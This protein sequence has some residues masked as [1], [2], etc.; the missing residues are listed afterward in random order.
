ML[1]ITCRTI[2]LV[3]QT[4]ATIPPGRDR[5]TEFQSMLQASLSHRLRELATTP[6]GCPYV[7]GEILKALVWLVAPTELDEVGQL[8]VAE[9]RRHVSHRGASMPDRCGQPWLSLCHTA[10]KL[11][12]HERCLRSLALPHR[13]LGCLCERLAAAVTQLDQGGV[14]WEVRETAALVVDWTLEMFVRW[15]REAAVLLDVGKML[16]AWE[17]VVRMR[18]DGDGAVVGQ[19]PHASTSLSVSRL[20]DG[21]RD[22]A[23]TAVDGSAVVR[24]QRLSCGICFVCCCLNACAGRP[25]R[26]VAMPV[27]S[28]ACCASRTTRPDLTWPVTADMAA[29]ERRRYAPALPAH[30]RPSLRAAT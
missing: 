23:S 19:S 13:L 18:A 26:Q 17:L 4:L 1:H 10:Q 12:T 30:N 7:R 6:L 25:W 15:C 5:Q 16:S 20:G 22:D 2:A 3:A 24:S 28:A 11:S 14:G 27:C 21:E 8:I 9:L 29:R